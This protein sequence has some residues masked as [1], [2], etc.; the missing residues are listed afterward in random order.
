MLGNEG[1]MPRFVKIYGNIS[2][3]IEKSVKQYV[4]DVE[5]KNFP[6]T[7]NTY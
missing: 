2:K 4:S 5:N 6:K 3:E 7:K 1:N